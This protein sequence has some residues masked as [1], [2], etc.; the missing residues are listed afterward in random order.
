MLFH[1]KEYY[2]QNSLFLLLTL[3][4][5]CYQL[6]KSM[7]NGQCF[8]RSILH[9]VSV[10]KNFSG[11]SYIFY[12]SNGNYYNWDESKKICNEQSRYKLVSIESREE[13]NFLNRTIQ[14]EDTI[15]YFIGLRK[16]ASTGMWRWLSDNSTVNASNKGHWPWAKGQPS[17]GH[18]K[19]GENCAQM[20]RNYSSNFGRYNDVRCNLSLAKAGF[21]CEL[22][23]GGGN[24]PLIRIT[25]S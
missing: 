8:L 16:D 4:L 25:R 10:K 7:V 22:T 21:I 24:R 3:P 9:S 14:K 19:S 15:E 17:D 13:W 1:F 12:S 6:I 11:S 20:Y 5:R 18:S 2:C 23:S